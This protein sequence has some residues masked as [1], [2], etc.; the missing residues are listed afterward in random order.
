MGLWDTKQGLIDFIE[1]KLTDARD[2]WA[3]GNY[4]LA[5]AKTVWSGQSG[6]TWYGAVGSIIDAMEHYREMYKYMQQ[7]G[8]GYD[9]HFTI[10]FFFTNYLGGDP[11]PEFELTWQKILIAWEAMNEVGM[12]WT[13]TSID[14]MRQHIWH[15]NPN[16]KWQENPFE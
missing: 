14:Q 11:P 4:D 10:P 2:E 15:K 8:S 7:Y 6:E 3:Y 12:M 16:I 5:I 13:I 1:G 9:P